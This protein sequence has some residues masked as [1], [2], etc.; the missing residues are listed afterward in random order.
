MQ[1]TINDRQ[2]TVAKAFA[3]LQQYERTRVIPE[4]VERAGVKKEYLQLETWYNIGR[5]H[6]QLVRLAAVEIYLLFD[7][8]PTAIVST[9]VVPS[10]D[11]YV[12]EGHALLR[13]GSERHQRGTTRVS[14]LP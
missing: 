3:F 2:H 7:D 4:N 5:A 9:G 14:H 6:Q 11:P 1:R 8:S 12:R 13:A 10:R